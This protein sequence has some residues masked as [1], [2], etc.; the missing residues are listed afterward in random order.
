MRHKVFGFLC[1][2]QP[3]TC[4]SKRLRRK[5]QVQKDLKQ[6]LRFPTAHKVFTTCF[7]CS[8]C[9]STNQEAHNPVSSPKNEMQMT[10]VLNVSNYS[11]NSMTNH[12]YSAYALRGKLGYG[13]SPMIEWTCD[14]WTASPPPPLWLYLKL[15]SLPLCIVVERDKS[16]TNALTWR[17]GP[18]GLSPRGQLGSCKPA[19]YYFGIHP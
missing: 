2:A 10:L 6:M 1:L 7:M 17:G 14:P 5:T 18:H 3:N 11:L 13:S 4:R 15:S 8:A 19:E 16:N 9:L 12:T